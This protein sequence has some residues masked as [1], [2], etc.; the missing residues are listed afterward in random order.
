MLFSTSLMWELI[1][2]CV[3][4]LPGGVNVFCVFT[5]LKISATKM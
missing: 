5:K 4:Q 2:R 3:K 1:F